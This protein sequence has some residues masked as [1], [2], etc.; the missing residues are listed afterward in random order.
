MP[1]CAAVLRLDHD[2][3]ANIRRAVLR[4]T[5]SGPSSTTLDAK[6]CFDDAQQRLVCRHDRRPQV[7]DGPS[8]DV[9]RDGHLPHTC[10]PE[11]QPIDRDTGRVVLDEVD[12]PA[13]LA[14][15]MRDRTTNARAGESAVWLRLCR[16][17]PT[18][19]GHTGAEL[20]P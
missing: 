13:W 9:H 8:L 10:R 1:L 18:F 12:V 20:G 14:F 17:P 16:D 7:A 6:T 19:F 3:R 15:V 11:T 5:L 4:P 2:I